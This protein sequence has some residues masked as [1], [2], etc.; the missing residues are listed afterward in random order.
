MSH[1]VAKEEEEKKTFRKQTFLVVLNI[2][3]PL[4]HTQT[5][6]CKQDLIRT[7]LRMDAFCIYLHM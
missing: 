5:H 4:T 1:E 2:K 3:Q 7:S 6:R